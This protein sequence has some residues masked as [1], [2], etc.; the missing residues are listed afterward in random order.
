[1]YQPGQMQLSSMNWLNGS[2]S[3]RPSFQATVCRTFSTRPYQVFA[4]PQGLLFLELRN[5]PGAP[6]RTNNGA[7]V[8]GAVLGGAIGATIAGIMTS[9]PGDSG[10]MENFDMC[11]EDER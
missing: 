5:K 7:I 6:G 10:R 4:M 8:A 2:A 11:S 3:D 1:M 9:G